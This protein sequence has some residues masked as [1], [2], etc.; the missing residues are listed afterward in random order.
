MSKL[1]LLLG[2]AAA[3][4]LAFAGTAKASAEQPGGTKTAPNGTSLDALAEKTTADL[5]K[6]D[7]A[8]LRKDIAAWKAASDPETAGALSFTLEAAV[9]GQDL[10]KWELDG[11]RGSPLLRAFGLRIFQLEGRKPRVELW[12]KAWLEILPVLSQ[13]LKAKAEGLGAAAAQAGKTGAADPVPDEKTLALILQAV[14]SQDPER[15]RAVAKQLDALGFKD[16]AA[17]LRAAADL[18][19]AGANANP[20]KPAPPPAVT[21]PPLPVPPPTSSSSSPGLPPIVTSTPTPALPASSTPTAPVNRGKRVAQIRKG[22]GESQLAARLL[23][24]KSEGLARFREL[25][26]INVPPFKLNAARTAIVWNAGEWANVPPSWPASEFAVPGESAGP[27]KKLPKGATAAP[28]P[29]ASS[30][31]SSS[32]PTAALERKIVVKKGEGVAQV[33]MRYRGK[34]YT[35]ADRKR[36]RDFNVP[37]FKKTKD[38]SGLVLNPNDKLRIPPEWP[39]NAAQEVLGADGRRFNPRSLRAASIALELHFGKAEPHKLRE[40][41]AA[42]RLQPTGEYGPA[43]AVILCDRFGIVPPLP[44][45]WGNGNPTKRRAQ[46]A[47]H[48][49]TQANRDPQRGDE[50]R[51]VARQAEGKV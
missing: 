45:S 49:Y 20:T 36:L 3:L 27:G 26:A 29:V 23:G 44:H 17:D 48:M 22:E 31:S 25:R 5:V 14:Q 38:G 1:P 13:S 2:A 19:E 30:S 4:G 15:M 40:F 33:A 21:Q 41:Q 32:G 9:A 28:A 8:A 11:T 47:R 46:F 7:I 50:F 51:R 43:T 42:E 12:S 10:P 35:D 34:A 16:A 6:Q 37:P 39:V 24:S 18:I